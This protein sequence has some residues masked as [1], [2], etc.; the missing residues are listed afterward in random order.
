MGSPSLLQHLWSLAVEE[1]FYLI[2][3]LLLVPGLVLVGRK[4]LPLL[5]VAGIAGS[6]ALMWLLYKPTDPSR[7]YYGTDTRAPELGP[8]SLSFPTRAR[9][10]RAPQRSPEGGSRRARLV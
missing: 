9:C 2:W 7:V 5:I 6:A 10:A 4:R 1:Q 3:P 8:A